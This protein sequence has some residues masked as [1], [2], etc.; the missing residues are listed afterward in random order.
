M[1]FAA[2]GGI[3]ALCGA[4]PTNDL[5]NEATMRTLTLLLGLSLSACGGDTTPVQD[6]PHED[7]AG[8]DQPDLGHA[9]EEFEEEIEEELPEPSGPGQV[10]VVIRMGGAE[11]AGTVE[12]TN[13]QGETV[14]EGAAGTTFTV[15]AGDY[16]VSGMLDAALL[17]GHVGREDDV[18][19]SPGQTAEVVFTYEVARIRLDVRRGGRPVNTWRMVLTREGQ[20]IEI[21]M[22]PS[23]EHVMMAPGRYSGVLTTGGARIEVNG[24]IFQGGAT[25][26]V[27]VNIN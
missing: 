15:E 26:D 22:Q 19:V 13:R 10:H 11:Q 27:P 16:H 18:L 8:D 6:D 17:P 20:D 1:T 14:A 4:I 7:T 9:D 24:L 2:K 23:T 25:M 12:V 21:P 5:G 3:V